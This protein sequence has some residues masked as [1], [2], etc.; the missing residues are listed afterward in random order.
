MYTSC[1]ANVRKMSEEQKANCVA[2][3]RWLPKSVDMPQYLCVAPH[4]DILSDYKA[5]GS[6][7]EYTKKYRKQLARLNP[8]EIGR[9][10]DGKI[11]LCYE[12]AEDFCHRHILA[13][14][15]R[16]H[17]WQCEEMKF[18]EQEN[19]PKETLDQISLF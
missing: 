14:W 13:S 17:G 8:N 5:G 19:P 4:P 10:L 18:H 16:E 7:E 3:C 15:L 2:V 1:F 9:L 12:K 6:E 11:L